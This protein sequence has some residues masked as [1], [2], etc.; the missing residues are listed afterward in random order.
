MSVG[1]TNTLL[2]GDKGARENK[3]YFLLKR[4]TKKARKNIVM[5]PI[6]FHTGII[7]NYKRNS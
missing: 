7:F 5:S 6:K 4:K 1:V 2:R 3:D